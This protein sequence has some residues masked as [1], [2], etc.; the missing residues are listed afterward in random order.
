M[1]YLELIQSLLPLGE[2]FDQPVKPFHKS[3]PDFITDP[4]RCDAR[5]YVSPGRLH[6][7]LATNC[8]RLMNDGLEPDLLSLPEYTLNSEVQDLQTRIDNQISVALEYACRSWHHHLTETGGETGDVIPH[9]RIFLEGKFLAWLEAL[10]VLEDVGSASVALEK[11][12][13]WLPE[14][15][16][17]V[18]CLSSG[19]DIG[20]IRLERITSLWT[21][22]KTTCIS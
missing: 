4:S 8:L 6:L 19:A 14:V 11:L 10:S 18:L 7:E 17:N 20:Q 1:L 13:L 15:C 3:F 16:F 22:L 9:L 12:I 2:D 5:F 21:S